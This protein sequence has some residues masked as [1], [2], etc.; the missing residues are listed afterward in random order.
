MSNVALPIHIG[1]YLTGAR[2]YKL[3]CLVKCVSP[4]HHSVLG[5]V[6]LI[7]HS[8]CGS[9]ANLV[10][11]ADR[12]ADLGGHLLVLPTVCYPPQRDS[13]TYPLYHLCVAIFHQAI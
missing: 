3:T 13:G 1:D 2:T 6:F 9:F 8:Y 10:H 12:G 5:D 4:P 7:I 11:D